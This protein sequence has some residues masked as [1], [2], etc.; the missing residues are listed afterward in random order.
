MPHLGGMPPLQV[1]LETPRKGSLPLSW[2]RRQIALRV[3]ARER[4]ASKESD[5][6]SGLACAAGHQGV[7]S[8]D[9]SLSLAFKGTECVVRGD[10]TVGMCAEHIFVNG[11]DLIDELTDGSLYGRYV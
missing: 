3:Q 2:V 4:L 9:N 5:R 8:G 10:Q 11:V 1:V 6:A 7:A